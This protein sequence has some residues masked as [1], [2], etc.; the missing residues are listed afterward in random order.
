[1]DEPLK[2][3]PRTDE[4]LKI[5]RGR[6]KKGTESLTF[7]AQKPWEAEGISRATWYVRRK[8]AKDTNSN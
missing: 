3:A 4:P 2:P 5:A 6:P 1:M 7:S 8:Q